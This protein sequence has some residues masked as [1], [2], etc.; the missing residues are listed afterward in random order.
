MKTQLVA[1][2]IALGLAMTARA[3]RREQLTPDTQAVQIDGVAH[4]DAHDNI[5]AQ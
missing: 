3:P 5:V 1:F 2:V 4:T